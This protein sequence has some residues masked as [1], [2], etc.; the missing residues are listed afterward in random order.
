MTVLSIVADC[1]ECCDGAVL[2]VHCVETITD[3]E[4]PYQ[5]RQYGVKEMHQPLLCD[6]FK[7]LDWTVRLEWNTS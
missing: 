5:L 2:E 4:Q 6:V 1:V 3:F 7:S